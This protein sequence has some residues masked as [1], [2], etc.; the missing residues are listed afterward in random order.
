M[1]LFLWIMPI[2]TLELP[3][4]CLSHLERVSDLNVCILVDEHAVSEIVRIQLEQTSHTLHLLLGKEVV[5]HLPRHRYE[6]RLLSLLEILHAFFNVSHV[7]ESTIR[8]ALSIGDL[9]K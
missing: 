9:A 8:P 1:M 7:P 6:R 4:L 5:S 2:F 3:S